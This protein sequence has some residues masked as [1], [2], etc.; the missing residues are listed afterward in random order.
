MPGLQV[1]RLSHFFSFFFSRKIKWKCGENCS[2]VDFPKMWTGKLEKAVFLA[3][4]YNFGKYA[5][6]WLISGKKPYFCDF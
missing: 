4:F 1:Q 3:I 6:I 2:K 5:P